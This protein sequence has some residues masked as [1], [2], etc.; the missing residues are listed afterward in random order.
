MDSSSNRIIGINEDWDELLS[1]GVIQEIDAGEGIFFVTDGEKWGAKHWNGIPIIPIK[2]DDIELGGHEDDIL[3]VCKEGNQYDTFDYDGNPKSFGVKNYDARDFQNHV[4]RSFICLANSYKRGGRCIAGIEIDSEDKII[5]KS[6]GNPKWIRPIAATQFGEI[7]NQVANKIKLLSHVSLS[8][9]VGCPQ[10]VHCE[11]VI[12]DGYPVEEC[13]TLFPSDSVFLDKLIDRTHQSIFGNRGKAVSVDMASRLDYS[14]MFIHVQNAKAYI[15]E[16]R[17]KSKSRMCFTYYG[18]EYDLPIT[19]PA[20]LEEFRRTPERF[21]IIHSVYLSL[22]LGLEYEGWH[23]KLVAGVI[24]PEYSQQPHNID[25]FSYMGQQDW[26]DEYESELARLL[27]KKAEIEGRINDIRLK[28][29]KQMETHGLDKVRSRQFSVSYAPSKTIMQF[30]S[31]AFREEY[32]ELYS[33][34]CKPKQ[35]EASIV[36]KRNKID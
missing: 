17:E 30:D 5:F 20:F 33:I 3:I 23:H 32:E 31:K 13:S 22:S 11:N 16:N 9:V 27:D 21:A 10:N 28:I 25:D 1:L 15:D 7:P 29:I 6:D 35:R 34:F 36:V 14:L 8:N 2:Y 4:S 18:T 19:D 24:I 26:F 12:G